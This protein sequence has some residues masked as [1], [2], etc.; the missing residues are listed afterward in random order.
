MKPTFNK[1]ELITKINSESGFPSWI[2]RAVV[3][4]TFGL[5]VSALAQGQKVQINN[6]GSFEPKKRAPR[7]GRNPHTGQAVPIP[8]RIVPVF[9]PSLAMKERV[10]K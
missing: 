6:F 9:K 8:E 1:D 4:R 10:G 3:D 7:T 2:V 5:I